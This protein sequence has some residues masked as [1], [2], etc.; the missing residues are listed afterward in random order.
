M[1]DLAP[2]QPTDLPQVE[3]LL[4]RVFG[5]DRRST[6]SSYQFRQGV[7]PVAELGMTARDGDLLVGTIRYWPVWIGATPALLLGPLAVAPDRRGDGIGE[8]LVRSSL[9]KARKAGY[10]TVVLVGD[11]NYYAKFGFEPAA[12]KGIILPGDA[13]RLMVRELSGDSPAGVVSPWLPAGAQP[14]AA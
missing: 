13:A 4:D 1:Y 14:V 8:K 3:A 11:P 10:E 5:H 7:A 6:K 2:H 12:P 9:M